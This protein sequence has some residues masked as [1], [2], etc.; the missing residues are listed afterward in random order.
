MLCAGLAAAGGSSRCRCHRDVWH[1]SDTSSGF[2]GAAQPVP[3]PLRMAGLSPRRPQEPPAS[4]S[5]YARSLVVCDSQ[6]P[7]CLKSCNYS[8]CWLGPGS[9]TVAKQRRVGT[10]SPAAARPAAIPG[11]AARR[12]GGNRFVFQAEIKARREG[13]GSPMSCKMG[14]GFV[15]F[16]VRPFWPARS[17]Y[18]N[19]DRKQF[20]L[21]ALGP[22]WL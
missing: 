1:V 16:N 9:R 17:I 14:G 20:C 2:A 15:V 21:E 10:G 11:R 4:P 22:N 19:G 5:S 3:L 12:P 8:A 6:A 18:Q 13:T 7:G